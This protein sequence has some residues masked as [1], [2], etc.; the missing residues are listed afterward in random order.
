MSS[1]IQRKKNALNVRRDG[2]QPCIFVRSFSAITTQQT[3]R[4]VRQ[5]PIASR[6]IARNGKLAEG[7][8]ANTGLRASCPNFQPKNDGPKVRHDFHFLAPYV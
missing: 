4:E 1:N 8:D 5:K 3:K 6:I 2:P 7:W